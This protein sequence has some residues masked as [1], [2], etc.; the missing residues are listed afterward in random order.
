MASSAFHLPVPSPSRCPDTAWRLL[1]GRG[2]LL[3]SHQ[4]EQQIGLGTQQKLILPAMGDGAGKGGR[5]S[6]APRVP[7][8]DLGVKTGWRRVGTTSG[9]TYLLPC[10]HSHPQVPQAT[11]GL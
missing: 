5:D 4:Q 10:M 8:Q 3:P 9:P 7:S 6:S 2:A 11:V 1:W